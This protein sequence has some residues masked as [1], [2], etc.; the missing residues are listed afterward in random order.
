MKKEYGEDKLMSLETQNCSIPHQRD[1][2][3]SSSAAWMSSSCRLLYVAYISSPKSCITLFHGDDYPFQPVTVNRYNHRLQFLILSGVR[4]V[5]YKEKSKLV[6]N[7]ML[8]DIT[9]C[10]PLIVNVRFGG[11]YHLHFWGQRIS[12]VRYEH[13]SRCPVLWLSTDYAAM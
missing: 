5:T 3:R 1:K 9:Q 7:T 2:R 4:S 10:S 12:R 11:K 8:W 6:K 13:E